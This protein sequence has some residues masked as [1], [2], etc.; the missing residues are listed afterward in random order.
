MPEAEESTADFYYAKDKVTVFWEDKKLPIADLSSFKVLG[1]GYA[2]DHEHV[3]YKTKIVQQADPNSF[4]IYPHGF[5]DADA[6]DKNN[7]YGEGVIV[8]Q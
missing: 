7:K 8:S 6:E 5:G 3:Y 1:H 2:I 4:K